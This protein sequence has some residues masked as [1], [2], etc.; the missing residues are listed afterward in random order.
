MESKTQ[1]SVFMVRRPGL[2]AQI[3]R[4]LAK[5]KINI[6]ALTMMD[7]SEHSVLRLLPESVPET[8]A[9]LR[10]LNV[11][12]TETEVLVVP[13]AN[14]PGAVADVCERLSDAHID[15]GYMY[16]TAGT[17][18]GKTVA[19]FKVPDIKK[20]IKVIEGRRTRSRD[21]KVKLRRPPARRGA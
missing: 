5:A 2:L 20:A 10:K 16:C 9:V 11:P 13:L 15:P 8:R 19:I 21:M 1:F 7:A 4:E 17:R 14:R 3:C 6:T 12:L 18:N